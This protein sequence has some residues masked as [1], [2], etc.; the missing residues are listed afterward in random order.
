MREGVKALLSGR[1]AWHD[2]DINDREAVMPHVKSAATMIAAEKADGERRNK[3]GK[4]PPTIR[5]LVAC[6]MRELQGRASRFPKGM[7]LLCATD[8]QEGRRQA[9]TWVKQ[10]KLPEGSFKITQ[11]NGFVSVI[12]LTVLDHHLSP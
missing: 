7:T 4:I 2:A 12:S 11:E 8:D 9:R 3:L 10:K 6:E 1:V 5:P